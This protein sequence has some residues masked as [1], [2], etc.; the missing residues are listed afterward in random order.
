VVL[1]GA[2]VMAVDTAAVVDVEGP[3]S[4]SSGIRHPLYMLFLSYRC[5]SSSFHSLAIGGT[6]GISRS[7]KSDNVLSVQ[8]RLPSITEITIPPRAAERAKPS[9][10]ERRARKHGPE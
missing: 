10:G 3:L 2:V 9:P 5:A 7:P 1:G 8:S 4:S 6:S